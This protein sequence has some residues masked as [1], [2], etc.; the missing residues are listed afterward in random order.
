[1]RTA[2]LLLLILFCATPWA[3]PAALAAEKFELP[4]FPLPALVREGGAAVEI[5]TTRL[6]RELH[7]GGV[8]GSGNLET[9]DAEYGLLR[10]DSL[11]TLA[12]WL[13]GACRAVGFDLAQ[14]RVQP[15]DG[16]VHA[17]LL[18]M[19]TAI[20]TLQVQNSSRLA[21]PIGVLICERREKWGDLPA[22]GERDAYVIFATEAG[23]MVYDPPTR[24]L[25]KLSDFP[26]REKIVRIRF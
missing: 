1:M 19:A 9:V 23:I 5:S 4:A 15:Y 21:V 8:R 13:E 20:A 7:R 17:R 10:S 12:G 25:S 14:A 2:R 6:L 22:D 11:D 24:Q 3:V 16:S 18:N 26:N